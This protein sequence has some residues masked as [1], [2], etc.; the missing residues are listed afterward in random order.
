MYFYEEKHFT[1]LKRTSC[2]WA[3]P[4]KEA[5]LQP[6]HQ[7]TMVVAQQPGLCSV[8]MLHTVQSQPLSLIPL[9]MSYCCPGDSPLFR[10][11]QL[12]VVTA[13]ASSRNLGER[14]KTNR[15]GETAFWNEKEIRSP[16]GEYCKGSVE[17][18][19]ISD[20]K[21]ICKGREENP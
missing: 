21:Q 7:Q 5:S 20:L 6:H 18:G 15:P 11:V 1:E 19:K 12:L 3:A 14:G 13:I 17:G 16:L 8:L 4:Q 2:S 9:A 10:C